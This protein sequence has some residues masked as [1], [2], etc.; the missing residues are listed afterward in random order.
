MVVKFWLVILQFL[1]TYIKQRWDFKQNPENS[2]HFESINRTSITFAPPKMAQLYV[3]IGGLLGYKT[4]LDTKPFLYQDRFCI[5]YRSYK[6]GFV[7]KRVNTKPAQYLIL[8]LKPRYRL[9]NPNSDSHTLPLRQSKYL[10]KN[11]KTGLVP[12]QSRFWCGRLSVGTKPVL[13]Q[14]V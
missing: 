8:R 1:V 5:F 13:M 4:C 6:T 9:L 2:Y 10:F 11:E 14:Q 3:A 7:P 12:M